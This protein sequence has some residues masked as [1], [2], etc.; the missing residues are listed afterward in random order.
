MRY[1]VATTADSVEVSW[2]DGDIVVT[3]GLG[4]DTLLQ[5]TLE[6][7]LD[8]KFSFPVSVPQV[9][10]NSTADFDTVLRKPANEFEMAV[11]LHRF[12]AEGGLNASVYTINPAI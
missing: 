7:F 5:R 8:E 4:K 6:G 10:A 3:K 1:I 9:D 12:P 2:A 11:A